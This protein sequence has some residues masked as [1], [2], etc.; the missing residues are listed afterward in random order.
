MQQTR[1]LSIPYD[2]A[3]VSHQIWMKALRMTKGD[4]I[5]ARR[6]ARLLDDSVLPVVEEGERVLGPTVSGRILLQRGIH[7]LLESIE[8]K[9]LG[10]MRRVI[11]R[12]IPRANHAWMPEKWLRA[13][14]QHTEPE[15]K[16]QWL[17]LCGPEQATWVVDGVRIPNEVVAEQTLKDAAEEGI[18]PPV[19]A[20]EDRPKV[21]TTGESETID[22]SAYV[23]SHLRYC[24]HLPK[25]AVS[26]GRLR[27]L[28]DVELARRLPCSFAVLDESEE[29]LLF[30]LL[31][32]Y[33]S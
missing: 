11:H 5:Q 31:A 1:A 33:A 7:A 21:V 18:V 15:R 6:L 2:I 10:R 14:V 20:C 23:R 12:R 19:E 4:A 16:G 22:L 9:Q 17:G 8:N 13:T 26:L 32:S 29:W 30:R 24:G 3:G 28:E 27:S 25:G